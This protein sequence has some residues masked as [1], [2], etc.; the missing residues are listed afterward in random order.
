ML[1]VHWQ[2]TLESGGEFGSALCMISKATLLSMTGGAGWGL[3]AGVVV[4][5]SLNWP[6]LAIS[7]FGG[8][9]AGMLVWNHNRRVGKPDLNLGAA[10]WTSIILVWFFSSGWFHASRADAKVAGEYRE[11]LALHKRDRDAAHRRLAEVAKVPLPR[12]NDY[13]WLWERD[14]FDR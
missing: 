13:P 2:R 1:A 6:V 12:A 7:I 10:V 14:D 8:L 11:L 3:G 9:V 5:T 4:L